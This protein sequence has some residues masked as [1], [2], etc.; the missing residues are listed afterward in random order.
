MVN[1]AVLT[2]HGGRGLHQKVD[3]SGAIPVAEHGDRLCVSAE[4]LNVLLD[5]LQRCDLVHQPV[6]CHGR[7]LVWGRIRVQKT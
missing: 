6:V 1:S 2:C 4:M 3:A 5:P 7:M